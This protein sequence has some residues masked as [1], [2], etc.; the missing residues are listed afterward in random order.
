[1]SNVDLIQRQQRLLARSELLRE[2]L[3]SQ[4]R[5]IQRPL[6][7]ADRVND[8]LQ[9]LYLRPYWPA[10]AV[11]LIIILKPMRVLSWGGR[12]WWVWKSVRKVQK[13]LK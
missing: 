1:M 12:M 7:F 13:L 9:W 6:A 10:A 5:V 4:S 11:T 2:S 8:G 3:A